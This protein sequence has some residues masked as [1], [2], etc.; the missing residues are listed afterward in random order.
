MEHGVG[1]KSKVMRAR[2]VATTAAFAALSVGGLAVVARRPSA[3]LPN[4]VG[5]RVEVYLGARKL[6][7]KSGDSVVASYPV[8]VG[9]GSMPTPVGSYSIR[10][11]EWNPAWVPPNQPWARRERPQPPG[12]S[13]N[14]MQVVKI[15]FKEP[16]YYIHGTNEEE[17]LGEAASH[18]CL[19]MD[20]D[21]AYNVARYL[22]DHGGEPR[23]ESWFSRILQFRSETKTVYL[24]RPVPMTVNP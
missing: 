2:R 20:P 10:H 8:A 9:R 13:T 18:G 11:I 16:D 22:M 3:P 15:F 6:Y 19:R 5:V 21:D 7:I 23:D 4:A 1:T 17:S 12:A 24:N 14:P